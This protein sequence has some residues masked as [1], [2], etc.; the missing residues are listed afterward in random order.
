ME[1][2]NWNK[3][4]IGTTVSGEQ[5]ALNCLRQPNGS[6]KYYPSVQEA[7]DALAERDGKTY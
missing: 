5:I 3:T 6:L 2:I 4:I 1:S 7:L